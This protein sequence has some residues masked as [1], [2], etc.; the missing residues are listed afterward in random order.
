[1]VTKIIALFLLAMAVLAMFGR[2]RFPGTGKG[3]PKAAAKPAKCP[4][5]GAYRIGKAGC[6]CSSDK[7][8]HKG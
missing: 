3:K 6:A 8:K 4:T 2:L 5:C 7:P 1:M